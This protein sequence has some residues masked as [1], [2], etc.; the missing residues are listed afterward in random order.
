MNDYER[1]FRAAMRELEATDIWP[2][3]YAPPLM[4]L[5]RK[6][7]MS[8]RPPHYLEVWQIVLGY[9]GFFT[10]IWGV[11]MWHVSWRDLQM[12]IPV[13][14]FISLATGLLFGLAMAFAIDRVRKK[15]KL[16]RWRNL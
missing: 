2:L 10:L 8:A 6:I 11:I 4:S 13:A 5:Q 15:W 9:G 3:N 14:V 12:T 7:G 16:S 1:R